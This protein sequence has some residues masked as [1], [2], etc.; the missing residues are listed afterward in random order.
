MT[1]A[2]AAGIKD[3]LECPICLDVPRDPIS[4]TC[5][6]FMC[7]ECA[8]DYVRKAIPSSLTEL[9]CPMCKKATPLQRTADA[10]EKEDLIL[11][12]AFMRV[13]QPL[14]VGKFGRGGLAS[15]LKTLSDSGVEVPTCRTLAEQRKCLMVIE[16]EAQPTDVDLAATV[17]FER[18][19]TLKMIIDLAN[20]STPAK[21]APAEA[22]PP[23]EAKPA[24]AA[25]VTPAPVAAKPVAPA[26][27]AAA[28][29]A[30]T[31]AVT[32]LAMHLC[33]RNLHPAITEDLVWGAA[34]AA[35]TV[36]S[37]DLYRRPTSTTAFIYLADRESGLRTL[38][39]LQGTTVGGG[40]PATIEMIDISQQPPN[41]KLR[42][43]NLPPSRSASATQL[44]VREYCEKYGRV[45]KV[46]VR[47]P[48]AGTRYSGA[49]GFVEF[50]AVA[51]ASRLVDDF[52]AGAEF[53]V[54]GRHVSPSYAAQQ[55]RGGDSYVITRSEFQSFMDA[56]AERVEA[57]HAEAEV[58]LKE[59]YDSPEMRTP[60]LERIPLHELAATESSVCD[61]VYEFAY[62]R[63]VE[64][65][66]REAARDDRRYRSRSR[67]AAR[68]RRYRS[69]SRGD[70]RS[71]SR[72]RGRSRSRGDRGSYG[73]RRRS[74]S[75]SRSRG[76][77]GGH[78]SRSRGDRESR[79]S[80]GSRSW[81]RR[82]SRSREDRRG[83][84]NRR[85]PDGRDS[86][87]LTLSL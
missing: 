60:L 13:G 56:D 58:V 47:E 49:Y 1:D 87:P 7:E 42:L 46:V 86:R 38:R 71:R 69:R 57:L 6:H 55:Q 27:V 34:S 48:D 59:M 65:A 72:G 33:L 82:R 25:P 15:C 36:E 11:K 68:D 54:G 29:A 35:G 80:R 70:R 61:Q 2:L 31:R 14:P 67:E 43:R 24:E 64:R 37:A 63:L 32:H 40:Q 12:S 73:D 26:P 77:S 66:A 16:L 3:A 39:N 81:S 84:R 23:V 8:R 28:P 17:V 10:E 76:R 85:S 50:D 9:V 51:S 83:S 44:A 53:V 41:R 75:R 78:R 52:L 74:R 22:A 19:A 4:M 30:P 45:L 62:N 18:D 5:S 20:R 79:G 21:A